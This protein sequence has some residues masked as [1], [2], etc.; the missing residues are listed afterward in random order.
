[1][2]VQG[3]T[4]QEAATIIGSSA[5]AMGKRLGRAKRRL[6]AAYLAQDASAPEGYP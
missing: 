3:F 4:A 2:V 5:A 1:M 6:L